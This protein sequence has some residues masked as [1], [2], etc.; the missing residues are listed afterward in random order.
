[1]NEK[2]KVSGGKLHDLTLTRTFENTV[3]LRCST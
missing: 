3:E 2:Y 1:M